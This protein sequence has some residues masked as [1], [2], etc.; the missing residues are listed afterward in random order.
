M[1]A[2]VSARS[3]KGGHGT[4]AKRHAVTEWVAWA[5][6]V[7]PADTECGSLGVLKVGDWIDGDPRNCSRCALIVERWSRHDELADPVLS[8]L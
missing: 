5:M 8:Q 1:R 6:G 3:V 2:Y 4:D 7:R